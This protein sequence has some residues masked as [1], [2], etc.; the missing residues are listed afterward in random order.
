MAQSYD[1]A[2]FAHHFLN[3][4]GNAKPTQKTLQFVMG[5]VGAEYG[6]G[7]TIG[8]TNNPL[9][10]CY[11]MPGSTPCNPPHCVQNYATF[12]D[13]VSANLRALSLPYYPSLRHALMTNDENHLGFNGHTM[14]TNIAEDLSVWVHGKRTPIDKS[15]ISNI[16]RIAGVS[17][18]AIGA[19]SGSNP[20]SSSGGYDPDPCA[21]CGPK[22]SQ[23]YSD[24]I[25]YIHSNGVN[26]KMCPAA[27]EQVNANKS[28]VDTAVTFGWSNVGQLAQKILSLIEDP[29]RIIKGVLGVLLIIAG[30][31]LLVQQ[32]MPGEV[33]QIAGAIRK[34]VAL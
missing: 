16:L 14:A 24:C 2:R 4:L 34:V 29:V 12:E 9:A 5:W 22:G 8:C 3:G 17:N 25:V 18:P 6:Q 31:Y 1:R 10:T 27:Q 19:D 13:G 26:G 23:A 11:G 32:L 28:A 33:K 21:K 15:Y 20:P 7:S 30:L